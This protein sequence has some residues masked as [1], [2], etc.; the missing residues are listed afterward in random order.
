MS[1]GRAGQSVSR[2]LWTANWKYILDQVKRLLDCGRGRGTT[3][4]S[5]GF[6]ILTGMWGPSDSELSFVSHGRIWL[7][8]EY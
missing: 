5:G 1:N 2:S 3:G 4:P 7:M 6:L 8:P